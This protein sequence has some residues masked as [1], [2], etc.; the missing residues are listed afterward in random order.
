MSTF[1]TKET[2]PFAAA[3]ID[4]LFSLLFSSLFLEL[5]FFVISHSVD[6]GYCFLPL[7]GWIV[8]CRRFVLSSS[9][10]VRR[11]VKGGWRHTI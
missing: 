11:F 5:S 7:V 10:E 4:S 3:A 8:Y 1:L 9:L 2:E 6:L